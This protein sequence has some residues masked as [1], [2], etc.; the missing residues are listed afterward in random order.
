MN[1]LRSA[2]V[3]ASFASLVALVAGCNEGSDVS[4]D[5]VKPSVEVGS[6]GLE[7]QYTPPPL[8]CPQDVGYSDKEA[9]FFQVQASRVAK[10]LFG[11]NDPFD[12]S[13]DAY[14]NV[15]GASKEFGP[16]GTKEPDL[17]NPECQTAVQIIH[18]LHEKLYPTTPKTCDPKTMIYTRAGYV[19][20]TPAPTAS[21]TNGGL[22]SACNLKADT[23]GFAVNA[24]DADWTSMRDV[25]PYLDGCWGKGLS[26]FWWTKEGVILD[27]K[28]ETKMNIV[29]TDPEPADLGA[30]LGST[31]G[32][33]AAATYVN[34]GTATNVVEWPGSWVSGSYLTPGTPCSTT[35]LPA[36]ALTSQQI[37]SAS[38]TSSY[39]KCL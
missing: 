18:H 39:R 27:P 19:C 13:V 23:F 8:I 24:S 6:K 37:V 26:G 1:H 16:W 34:T 4:T 38:A 29:G 11:G 25:A 15:V 5:D 33:T 36:G 22:S 10:Y 32:A 30:P 31:T 20:P 35:P 17:A 7:P 3:L 28:N 21:L 9:A 12:T 2:V 14:G